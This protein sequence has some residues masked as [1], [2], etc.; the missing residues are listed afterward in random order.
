MAIGG[1]TAVAGD[2]NLDGSFDLILDGLI[3]YSLRGV[4]RGRIAE[5]IRCAN[6]RDTPTVSLDIPSGVDAIF[7]VWPVRAPFY[8]TA[9]VVRN[10]R[11]VPSLF[12]R[13]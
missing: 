8:T 5:R 9:P 13:R 3:G 11:L 1:V 10:P 4:P 12:A 6:H 2:A 7:L